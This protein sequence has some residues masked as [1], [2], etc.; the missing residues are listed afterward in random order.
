MADKIGIDFHGVI[1]AQ[2]KNFAEFC[3]EIRLCGI[4]VFVISG[5]PQ[6]DIIKYLQDHGIEYDEVW[7]ILDHCEIEG[8]VHFYDDGSFFVPTE[9]WDKAKA[10]Y[11]AEQ[12]IL[13][14]ID[15]SPVYGKYFV[16]PYCQ[17]DI[18]NGSCKLDQRVQID[19]NQPK[20]AAKVI[21]DFISKSC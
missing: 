17:Y 14:H 21:A 6:K 8:N 5:G 10:H 12:N 3:H 20:A 7:G 4:K 1:S 9:I 15:D 13:F 16:T 19:F 18:G 11:C 2:P